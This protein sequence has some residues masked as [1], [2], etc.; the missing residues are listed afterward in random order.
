[1]ECLSPNWILAVLALAGGILAMLADTMVPEAFEHGG[2]VVAR[3][4]R[5]RRYFHGS[6]V[7]VDL[8]GWT[9]HSLE[10]PEMKAR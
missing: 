4:P 7:R 5:S 9:R 8:V 1:L 3:S 10:T 6:W 2:P